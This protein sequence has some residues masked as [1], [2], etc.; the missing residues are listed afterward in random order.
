MTARNAANPNMGFKAGDSTKK[1]MVTSY[2]MEVRGPTDVSGG[3]ERSDE[4]ERRLLS[5]TIDTPVIE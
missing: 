2:L 5:L 3:D 1:S 4:K